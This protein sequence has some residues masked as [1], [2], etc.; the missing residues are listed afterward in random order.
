MP[1][2]IRIGTW[3][4]LLGTGDPGLRGGQTK[5]PSVEFAKRIP[6]N[7]HDLRT[8][9]PFSEKELVLVEAAVVE[10]I[11]C[12]VDRCLKSQFPDDY[13][14]R[15]MY[16][17]FGI[18]RLLQVLGHNPVVVG[19]SFLAFVVSRHERK[20]SMQG[21]ASDCGEHSHYWVELNGF[22]IDLGTYYLPVESSFPACEVPAVFWD[23]SYALPRGLRYDPEARYASMEVT[24]LAP[25]IIEKMEPFLA[26][27][28]ARM[29]KPLVKPK[30]GKW[31]VTTP[32]SI[33]R[34]ASKGDLWAQGV[35]RYQRMPTEG[36]PI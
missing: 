25:H 7:G 24:H 28:H 8:E 13:H 21:Y 9:S 3:P 14:K 16:A 10:R 29:A 1:W 35:I 18:H 20:G 23:T 17:S 32:S 22:I 31:L 6:F 27:C 30:I 5:M 19:G 15:C 12:V 26:A 33:E 11:L 2:S 36:L 4:N 34:A